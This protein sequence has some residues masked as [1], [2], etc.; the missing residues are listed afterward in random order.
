MTNSSSSPVASLPPWLR[1][2]FP[3]LFLHVDDVSHELSDSDHLV[4]DFRVRIG[5][6]IHAD[7]NTIWSVRI[8][9]PT[10]DRRRYDQLAS[11]SAP[12]TNAGV[13]YTHSQTWDSLFENR[14]FPFGTNSRTQEALSWAGLASKVELIV[15]L[16]LRTLLDSDE[17]TIT[18]PVIDH[19]LLIIQAWGPRHR[20]LFEQWRSSVREVIQEAIE[21][22]YEYIQSI[23]P[24]FEVEMVEGNTDYE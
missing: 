19:D 7:T 1:P 21:K 15:L 2:S 22:I 20:M 14:F 5:L 11:G 3:D 17:E 24:D 23:E 8:I 6:L 18:K 16:R 9:R 10:K 13:S 4:Y 12:L